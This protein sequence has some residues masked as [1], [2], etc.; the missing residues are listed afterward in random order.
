MPPNQS[1]SEEKA[2]EVIMYQVKMI[3]E[4]SD[5]I[6]KILGFLENIQEQ[7]QFIPYYLALVLN[8]M[9][10]QKYGLE[11]EDF[12]ANINEDL[13]ATNPELLKI[14]SDMEIGIIKIMESLGAINP[15]VGKYMRENAT[16]RDL[17]HHAEN[18]LQPT[19]G[20]VVPPTFTGIM[21]GSNPMQML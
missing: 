17:L 11:E 4:R 5:D 12:M 1:V 3:E 18:P 6:K 8:D 21:S 9:A 2:K 20:L 15:E 10:F 13:V 16:R 7:I 14:F 19:G